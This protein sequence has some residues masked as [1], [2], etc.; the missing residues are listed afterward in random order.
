MEDEP[1][2]QENGERELEPEEIIIPET[3]PLLAVRDVVVFPYM[4]I[5][6]FVGR[7]ISIK[8]VDEALARDRFIFIASQKTPTEDDPDPEQIYEYGTAALIMRMLKMPDGR[9][10]ILIQ[11]LQRGKTVEYIQERPHLAVK[12]EKVIEP[13][14]PEVSIELEARMR[15]VKDQLEKMVSLGRA[16]PPDFMMVIENISDAGRISDVVAANLNLKVENAQKILETIEPTERL[17][18]LDEILNREL[19]LMNMQAKIQSQAKEGITKTQR[20]YFLREQIKAIQDELGELDERS[21]E[22]EELKAKIEAAGMPE[23]VSKETEKQLKRLERMHQDSAE[24]TVVR[25][26]LDWLLELPWNVATTDVLDLKKAQKILD[27]DHYNLEK[28]KERILE[29]LGV[30]KLKQD[31]RGPILCFIGPPGVGKTSLG[32]SIARAIGRKFVRISLGGLRDE[33]EIR[34]HLRTYI[35]ALPGKIIQGMKQA[36]TNN[37]IFM[38]DEVDKLGTD[39]RGDPSSALLEILDPEQNSNFTDHYLGVPFDLSKVLF[40]ATANLPDPIQP[41]LRDRMEII[42]I[43]GY[44]EEEKMVIARKFLIPRQLEANGLK[45]EHLDI[46]DRGLRKVIGQYTKEAGLRNLERELAR[47]CRKVARQ[48]AEGQA[49]PFSL[50]PRDVDKYLGPPRFLYGDEVEEDEIGVATGLAWT[51]SGGDIIHVEATIM[52]G[53]GDLTLTGHLGEVMK[54]SAH[55][56]LSYAR[57]RSVEFG[58]NPRFFHEKDV[59]IHVPAGAI[60]KD[61]PSAG[62]TMATALVSAATRVPVRRN[63][64]MTG[65]ITLRGRVLPI[66]GLKEKALAAARFHIKEILIPELNRKD[67]VDVPPYVKK[68]VRFLPVKN[69][70]QVIELALQRKAR[71][72]RSKSTRSPTKVPIRNVKKAERAWRTR[73]R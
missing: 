19:E 50:R 13:P 31:M 8:S 16:V 40:I 35:G 21:S 66:G 63:L 72:S 36:G 64:A 51:E 2:E 15:N 61:G 33:A 27:E 69:V 52:K 65:E 71:G 48:V 11:G 42:T 32:K 57:S 5:T 6:L 20:E 26:Y 18:S 34:G 56:A 45:R 3:L 41:T 14:A 46:S 24:A 4:I 59:H 54:E 67:L 70:D 30:R 55:A 62:I 38:M 1:K 73:D 68:K 58:L 7:E 29:Y 49:G 17:T 47:I 28:V 53:K 25:T 39:F 12:I 44:T 37:P 9:V 23:E 10:K 60:P 43:P 22:I